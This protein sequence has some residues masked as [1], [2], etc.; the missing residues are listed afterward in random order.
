MSNLGVVVREGEQRSE[1]TLN[2]NVEKE[3][4]TSD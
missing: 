1:E 3:R 4:L 2:W